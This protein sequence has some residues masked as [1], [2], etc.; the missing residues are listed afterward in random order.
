MISGC[1][2]AAI[3]LFS[4]G[5]ARRRAIRYADRECGECDEIEL[6]PYARSRENQLADRSGFPHFP[7][8]SILP[9]RVARLFEAS[10]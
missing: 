3:N 4:G 9:A 2:W 1:W 5:D 10:L 8:P 7:R 6:E